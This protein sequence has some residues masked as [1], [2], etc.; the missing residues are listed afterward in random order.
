MDCDVVGVGANNDLGEVE[1]VLGEEEMKQLKTQV[2]L[3]SLPFIVDL[4]QCLI[5]TF[6][7]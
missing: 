6:A 4:S 3:I 7:A 5:V 2:R 1:G